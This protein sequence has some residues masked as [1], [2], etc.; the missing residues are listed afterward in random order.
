MVQA[1]VLGAHATET[2]PLTAEGLK[3]LLSSTL[4][5]PVDEAADTSS[6]AI[7]QAASRALGSAFESLRS[8]TVLDS[9]TVARASNDIVDSVGAGG[10]GQWLDTV[11][12]HHQGTYQHCLL[13]TGVLT[14]FAQ[15]V[16]MSQADVS[17]L[18]TAGLLH[19][20]GKATIPVA[21]LE[22]PGKLSAEEFAEIARHPIE[23]FDYLT[24]HA[25][26]SPIF[27]LPSGATT[28][29]STAAAT[30][31]ASWPPRSAIS[32]AS[33]PS[34]ISMA[35]SANAAPTSPPCSR[36]ALAILEDMCVA[37]KLETA[38]VRALRQAVETG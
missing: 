38:L 10:L 24:A 21:I 14:N 5:Q 26:L 27:W 7:A 17:K 28:N 8:N 19:D 33:S 16:G 2:R 37:G 15:K 30:P 36:P 1:N 12:A 11:R 32:P 29:I 13:V 20:I 23:G 18:T 6:A 22:K 25:D 4:P 3:R 35:H 31:M 9:T 34:A